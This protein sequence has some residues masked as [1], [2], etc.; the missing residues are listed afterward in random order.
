MGL[1]INRFLKTL[2]VGALYGGLVGL[3]GCTQLGPQPITRE[4]LAANL[5]PLLRIERRAEQVKYYSVLLNGAGG[6]GE[7]E[8]QALKDHYDIYYVY[9]LAAN[10]NL[11]RGHL[12]AY[13]AHIKLAEKELDSME[14]ILKE[15]LAALGRRGVEPSSQHRRS[16]L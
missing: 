4:E 6:I 14:A 11:G 15:T 1:W 7:R 2:R 13:R 10:T 5:G 3:F 9:Y 8:A 12:D 16:G